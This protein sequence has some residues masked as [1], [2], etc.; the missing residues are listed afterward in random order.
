MERCPLCHNYS[1]DFYQSKFFICSYC[2]GISRSARFLPPP[3]QE[4]ARYELHQ[5][6]IEDE[7]YRQFLAPLLG[8]VINCYGPGDS[9]LDFGAGPT[10]GVSKL[11]ND[12]GYKIK[13]YDPFFHNYP[14][15]LKEK[16]DYIICC[17]VIE[18]FHKPGN[19][20]RLLKGLLK[21]GGSLFCM[22]HLYSQEIDFD[23]WYYKNDFTHV[24][25]YQRETFEFIKKAFGFS[26]VKIESRLIQLI[27]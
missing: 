7:G 23:N 26:G 15:L 13:L 17:E 5:N 1:E 8:S 3:D 10:P 22:T 27:G 6:N 9:G 21:P 16:Y 19:E 24:F 4:K 2:N 25:F 14:E 20:F 11:L 12:K 18:H